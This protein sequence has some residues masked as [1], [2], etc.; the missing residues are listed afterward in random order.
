MLIVSSQQKVY[1][2]LIWLR[3]QNHLWEG[4]NTLGKGKDMG[5]NRRPKN[6]WVL[7]FCLRYLKQTNKN[8]ET[9]K[10]K[11]FSKEETILH[12]Q[13]WTGLGPQTYHPLSAQV[14][15]QCRPLTS[16]DSPCSCS[17]KN[18]S[19]KWKRIMWLILVQ[20]LIWREKGALKELGGGLPFV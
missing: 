3:S 13:C 15:I 10:I 19:L 17:Q 18:L 8:R 5:D 20:P 2:W 7:D 6:K 14:Q 4:E 16:P 1:R 9:R 12:F 11:S